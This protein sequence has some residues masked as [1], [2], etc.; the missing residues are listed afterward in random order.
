MFHDSAILDKRLSEKNVEDLFTRF[1]ADIGNLENLTGYETV[2]FADIDGCR[3][4]ISTVNE[5]IGCTNA[6]NSGEVTDITQEVFGKGGFA[7]LLLM[8]GSM[9]RGEYK[10][11]KKYKARPKRGGKGIMKH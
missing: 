10:K 5:V 6:S 3:I 11:S 1:S 8:L 4:G 9:L 2:D 7:I